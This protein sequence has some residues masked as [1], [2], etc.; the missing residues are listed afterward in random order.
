MKDPSS[1]TPEW[2]EAN[3]MGRTQARQENSDTSPVTPS[4]LSEVCSLRN[5][6]G[7]CFIFCI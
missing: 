3:D 5:S 2:P 4:Q 7:R 6:Q 1:P